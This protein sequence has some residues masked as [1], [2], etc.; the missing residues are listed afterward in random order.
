MSNTKK[1]ILE[2]IKKR[3]TL[4]S[5]DLVDEIGLGR[6][7]ISKHLKNL[8]ES[9]EL[10]K[11]G[12]TKSS[13]YRMK[14]K[15]EQIDLKKIKLV[16]KIEGL[17]EH[18]V[19]SELDLRLGLKKELNKNA[20]NIGFYAFGEMLNN[21]IDH[22]E[23]DR[24]EIIAEVINGNFYFEIKDF[25]F[26]VFNR[27][28]EYYKLENEYDAVNWL[29]SGKKTSMPERHSGEGI[30]FTSKV[31]DVFSL[32]SHELKLEI[33]NKKSDTSLSDQRKTKGTVVRF[34]ISCNTKKKLSKYFEDYTDEDF[35]F[36]KSKS[37][38]KIVSNTSA[39]SRS[40]AKKLL[41]SMGEFNKIVLD[42]K[43]V[44]EIGQAF[45]DEVFRVYQERHPKKL[46]TWINAN[47]TIEF[48]IRRSMR[49]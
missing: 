29:L 12:S 34:E 9:G 13:V 25:G 6:Q 35:N 21:A 42:F 23:S 44:T 49:I 36:N 8:V 10:I 5:S 7:T 48:M 3:G 1:R 28:K 41:A 11:T 20:E 26:G 24:V 27:I 31:S 39:I 43:D 46:I 16:K 22:S 17:E 18:K 37:T 40:Q 30:F 47:D 33:N 32:K 2:L 19:Y 45:C 4:T 14:S 15:N 38:I